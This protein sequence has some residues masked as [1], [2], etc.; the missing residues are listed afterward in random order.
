MSG[1]SIY[2]IIYG[3]NATLGFKGEGYIWPIKEGEKI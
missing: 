1:H 2:T 3:E